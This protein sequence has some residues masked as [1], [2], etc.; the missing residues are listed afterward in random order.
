MSDC[1]AI[2]IILCIVTTVYNPCAFSAC[3]VETITVMMRKLGDTRGDS[4]LNC[5]VRRVIGWCSLEQVDETNVT[6][7]TSAKGLCAPAL[8]FLVVDL[9]FKNANCVKR[10]YALGVEETYQYGDRLVPT[11]WFLNRTCHST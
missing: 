8:A 1:T 6:V 2:T 7:V 4:V 9:N 3:S 10:K 5:V 11:P